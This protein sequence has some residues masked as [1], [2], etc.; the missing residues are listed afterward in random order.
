MME[1]PPTS[2]DLSFEGALTVVNWLVNSVQ[3]KVQFE[4]KSRIS[5]PKFAKVQERFNHFFRSSSFKGSETFQ[6]RLKSRG[7]NDNIK[8]REKRSMPR[9]IIFWTY[10]LK[11]SNDST[12]STIS[13]WFG[14][15][16][17]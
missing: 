15:A 3:Q 9:K 4:R 8:A 2:S 7:S 10:F 6:L 11:K 14:R 16:G 1:F 17:P 5:A 12:Q 13:Q